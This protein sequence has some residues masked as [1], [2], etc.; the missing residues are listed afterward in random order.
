MHETPSKCQKLHTL[1]SVEK[2][3]FSCRFCQRDVRTFKSSRVVFENFSC[4][5]CGDF[6]SKSVQ[7]RVKTACFAIRR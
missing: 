5:I 4:E 7:F 6:T 1:K 3:Y 2:E